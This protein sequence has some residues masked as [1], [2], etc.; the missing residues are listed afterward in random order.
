MENCQRLQGKCW[1][2]LREFTDQLE[3]MLATASQN[4]YVDYQ[5]YPGRPLHYV[6]TRCRRK[7]GEARNECPYRAVHGRTALWYL[8]P[9]IIMTRNGPNARPRFVHRERLAEYLDEMAFAAD[10]RVLGYGSNDAQHDFVVGVVYNWL[11]GQLAQQQKMVELEEACGNGW[12]LLVRVQQVGQAAA[13]WGIEVKTARTVHPGN[14]V[15]QLQG[16][17]AEG[18]VDHVLVVVPW[19]RQPRGSGWPANWTIVTYLQLGLS[20][21]LAVAR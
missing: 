13:C 12:D 7:C 20:P 8:N 18:Q 14:T 21:R 6:Q 11:R 16:Y 2:I 15:R 1:E 4:L 5:D 17:L 19:Y 3:E 9:T 10:A